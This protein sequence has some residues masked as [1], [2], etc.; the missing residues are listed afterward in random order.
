MKVDTFEIMFS[1]L[2]LIDPRRPVLLRNFQTEL[3]TDKYL[4]SVDD[5]D[6]KIR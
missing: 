1:C 2:S 6:S 5:D 3:M 4:N